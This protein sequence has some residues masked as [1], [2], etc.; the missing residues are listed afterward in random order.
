MRRGRQDRRT[1]R[2]QYRPLGPA[3]H[4]YI[5]EYI[6]AL[7]PAARQSDHPMQDLAR[8]LIA[9]AM[10]RWTADG[11]NEAGRVIKDALKYDLTVHRATRAAREAAVTSTAGLRHEHI[12]PRDLLARRIITGNLTT[13]DS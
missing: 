12:V 4:R 3:E 13:T 9:I 10:W 8:W 5:A 11:V 1:R 7:V 2:A 6:H